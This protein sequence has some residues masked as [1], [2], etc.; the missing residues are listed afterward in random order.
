MSSLLRSPWVINGQ[1]IFRQTCP[2]GIS[3]S[4]TKSLRH[5]EP[6]NPSDSYQTDHFVRS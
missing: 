6:I 1:H 5:T 3:M 2:R 4:L